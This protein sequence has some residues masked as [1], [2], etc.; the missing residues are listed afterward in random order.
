LNLRNNKVYLFM[1]PLAAGYAI[2]SNPAFAEFLILQAFEA[3]VY[4]D[5]LFDMG[6]VPSFSVGAEIK[7]KLSIIGLQ[8]LPMTFR[9]GYDGPTGK[10]LYSF[11]FSLK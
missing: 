1:V 7:C 5:L 9:F 8:S 3:G 2:R 11:R 4:C 6:P 10:Q